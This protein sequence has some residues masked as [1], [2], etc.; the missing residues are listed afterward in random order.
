MH[1]A[2][3]LSLIAAAALTLSLLCDAAHARNAAAEPALST[4]FQT[5]QRKAILSG[6]ADKLRDAMLG[7]YRL[8][9][10]ELRK[11]ASV[12]AKE[13]VQWVFEGPFGWKFEGLRNAQGTDALHL[14][15]AP[16]FGGDRVLALITGIQTMMIAAYG[17]KTEFH[18]P[19]AADPMQLAITAH[20][21][22][23][24]LS[25]LGPEP[26]PSH[27]VQ[28]GMIVADADILST[29]SAIGNSLKQDAERLTGGTPV[30]PPASAGDTEFVPL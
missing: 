6:H 15:F 27:E 30:N 26:P 18:F 4:Q 10:H 20:N 11:S 7:L 16:E 28:L 8:N 21:L 13:M 2:S 12:S 25:R 22:N 5:N 17:G 19:A 1:T 24:V 23:L 3:C 14:A 29:L 9:P